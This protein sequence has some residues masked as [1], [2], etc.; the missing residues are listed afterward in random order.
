MRAASSFCQSAASG[1]V[2]AVMD[3]NEFMLIES[4]ER[5][6]DH[7]FRAHDY[8]LWKMLYGE[9]GTVPEV[10]AGSPREDGLDLYSLS[11]TS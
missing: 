11:P 5:S 1:S 9:A 6:V 10:G 3:S 8:L 7:L 4:G 2:P